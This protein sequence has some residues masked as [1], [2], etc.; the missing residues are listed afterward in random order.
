MI[1]DKT[2]IKYD[3]SSP[4]SQ[5]L[6][7]EFTLLLVD[8]TKYVEERDIYINDLEYK[9]SK[10]SPIK[11]F[12]KRVIIDLAK[13][14]YKFLKKTGLLYFVKR[15]LKK[16]PRVENFIEKKLKNKIKN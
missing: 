9:L 15:V 8:I 7:E 11:Y 5:K 1:S 12:I 14:I 16:I 2:K 4:E 3:Y 13:G 10:Q 6:F